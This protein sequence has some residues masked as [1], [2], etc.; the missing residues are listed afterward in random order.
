MN[1]GCSRRSLEL[2]WRCISDEAHTRGIRRSRPECPGCSADIRLIT[3]INEECVREILTQI[4]EPLEKAATRVCAW[5][6][7]RLGRI[8]YS[9]T[10]WLC[11]LVACLA[12][13]ESADITG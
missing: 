12:V 6:P 13:P 8:R 5:A 11:R 2:G 1:G 10:I 9:L 4:G 3:F 7:D